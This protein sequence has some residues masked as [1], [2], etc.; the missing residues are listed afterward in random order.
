M[1][2]DGDLLVGDFGEWLAD[3]RSAIRGE[4]DA[5]VPCDGCSAC[6]TAG[7]FVHIG[8]DE[9]ATLARI[10]RRLLFPAPLMPEGHVV[11]PHDARGHCPLL[12]G[13]L[14]SIYEH[15]PQTCRTYDCRVFAATG[16]EPDDGLIAERAARWRFTYA[17]E[18][19]RDAHQEMR[20][21]AVRIRDRSE[22]VN[23]TE[24]AVRALEAADRAR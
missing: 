16:V 23:A 2:A 19:D 6:C 9:T 20:T 15:R 18:A 3:M 4:R 14:C 7:Q 22:G 5:D 24:R 12:V 13:G 11:I 21:T 1:G 10:P 17:S 8:P